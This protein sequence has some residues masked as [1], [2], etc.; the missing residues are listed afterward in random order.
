MPVESPRRVDVFSLKGGVGKTSISILLAQAQKDKKN[1]SVLVV[2]A[3]LTGTCIGD[4]LE[5][6][7][8][9]GW[10]AQANLAH[11]ICGAPE[12]LDEQL[13]KNLPVY[14]HRAS[15]PTNEDRTP[16]RLVK[17][18]KTAELLFCPSHAESTRGA[19][20]ALPEVQ[21]SV[22]QAITGHENAGG[23]IGFVIDT[24]IAEVHENHPLCGVVVDHGPGLAA[25]Q[26][27]TLAQ[28]RGRA[29]QRSLFVTT[30]DAV[31]LA[32]IHEYSQTLEFSELD[33]TCWLVNKLGPTGKQ[34]VGADFHRN[35]QWFEAALELH[36]DEKLSQGYA[37]ATKLCTEEV[38]EN[39]IETL[40][41]RLF[42]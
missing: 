22:L 32:T 8:A 14:V 18:Q 10:S 1:Q 6:W 21:R 42:D 5:F 2:D 30:G 23:F 19:K 3:D 28:Q 27:A 41:A 25:L 36:K 20:N 38:N 37:K 31:D 15:P 24:L 12:T 33:A 26:A 40:R 35:R 16:R 17:S 7:A 13:R 11:L 29:D 9:P 34:E 39:R 4:L